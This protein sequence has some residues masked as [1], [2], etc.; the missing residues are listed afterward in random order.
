MNEEFKKENQD[1]ERKNSN[2]NIIVDVTQDK[3]ETYIQFIPVQETPKINIDEIEEILSEKGIIFGVHEEILTDLI[4]KPKFNEK[5]L[6]ASGIK[7]EHG[8]DGKIKYFFEQNKTVIVKKGEKIAE[9]IPPEQGKDGTDVFGEKISS[10]QGKDVQ[11]PK[12]IYAG[13]SADDEYSIVSSARGY[14]KI[15][16]TEIKIL[17]FFQLSLSQDRDKASIKIRK[18]LSNNDFNEN[19]L[20]KFLEDKRIVY[21]IKE[22]VLKKIFNKKKFEKEILIAE[23][24]PVRH[25]IQGK[26]KYFFQTE[27][28]PK[29]DE[30]GNVDYKEL[31]L[32]QNVKK[33]SKLAEKIPPVKGFEGITIFGEK[34]PP[35]EGETVSLPVGKNTIKDGKDPNILVA[36]MDGSV[37]LNENKVDV[38]P[39][40][41]VKADV[42]YETGNIDFIGSVIVAGD[43]KSGFNIKARGVVQVDGI[44]EDSLIQSDGNVLIKGGF[45]GKGS[46]KIISNGKVMVKFCENENIVAEEDIIVSDYVMH[47]NIETS[48]KLMVTNQNGLIVGGKIYALKGI[49]A[50]VIGNMNYTNTSL[51]VG[52]ARNIKEKLRKKNALLNKNTENKKNAEKIIDVYNIQKSENMEVSETKEEKMKSVFELKE[53]LEQERKKLIKEIKELEGSLGNYKNSIV[54]ITDTV[55]PGTVITIYDKKTEVDESL[56]Y[57]FY[58]YVGEEIIALDLSDL[59]K[60]SNRTI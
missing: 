30:H 60:D 17:P 43:V 15:S 52:V 10:V 5:I 24:K 31:S 27:V 9:I 41:V 3:V 12:L 29:R 23:E 44:V 22:D 14:L 47:G 19:D 33:G 58:R 53:Q 38:D 48:G 16:Q 39:V 34:I 28:K 57:V 26:I 1:S 36:S 51:F 35:E 6:I 13:S 56:Q 54:K 59:K 37:R 40:F 32:I 42:D 7:P 21:G 20:K 2:V 25:G 11:L 50:R 46:G 4:E 45:I 55:F 49:E 18:P 8:K